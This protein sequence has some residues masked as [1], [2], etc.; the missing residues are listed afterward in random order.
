MARQAIRPGK[1]LAEESAELPP[2]TAGLARQI[3]VLTNRITE[4]ALPRIAKCA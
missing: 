3:K 2:S 4:I 1:H